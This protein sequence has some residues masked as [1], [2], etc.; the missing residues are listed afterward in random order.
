[1]PSNVLILMLTIILVPKEGKSEVGNLQI[2]C[3]AHN[4][5]RAKEEFGED[6]I[7]QRISE[8]G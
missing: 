1:M 8:K 2:L 7:R 3:K 6:L 4:L 5:F